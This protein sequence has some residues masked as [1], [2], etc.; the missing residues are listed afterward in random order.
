MQHV[1]GATNYGVSRRSEPPGIHAKPNWRRRLCRLAEAEAAPGCRVY[2]L[3]VPYG[4][5][6]VGVIR[7]FLSDQAIYGLDRSFTR[8]SQQEGRPR[9]GA[10]TTSAGYSTPTIVCASTLCIPFLFLLTIESSIAETLLV[11][12]RGNDSAATTRLLGIGASTTRP[13]AVPK[14]VIY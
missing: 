2:E 1:P 13:A 8:A 12:R 5:E 3:W 11:R 9:L 6:V 10:S 7:L 14:H 4:H